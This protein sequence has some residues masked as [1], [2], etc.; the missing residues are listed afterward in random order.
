MF[1]SGLFSRACV[2]L[3][4]LVLVFTIAPAQP[5]QAQRADPAIKFMK[6]VA[7][8]MIG[9]AKSGSPDKFYKVIKKY[10][11]Y[12]E[13]AHYALGDFKPRLMRKDRSRYYKGMVRYISRYAANEARKYPVAYAEILAPVS[14]TNRGI[15]VNSRV[16]LADKSIYEVR[17]LLIPRGR[18]FLVRDAQVVTLSPFA[19]HSAWL[20]PFLRDLFV[21]FITENGGRVRA[22]LLAL[23]QQ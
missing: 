20:S 16:H 5:T 8:E 11:H 7:K 3:A 12:R 14:R 1:S 13:I 2:V 23:N 21:N 6:R 18:T 15:Y 22:L 4:T 17:W 10:G 9:A 19:P